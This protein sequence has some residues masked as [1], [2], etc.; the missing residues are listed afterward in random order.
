M[1]NQHFKLITLYNY[2]E[3]IIQYLIEQLLYI[4]YISVY[5]H[6]FIGSHGL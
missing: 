6:Y 4:V 5:F 2:C 3:Q 1:D